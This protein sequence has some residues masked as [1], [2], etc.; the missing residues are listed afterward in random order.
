MHFSARLNIPVRRPRDPPEVD[1]G[2]TVE[3]LV[4]NGNKGV[5]QYRRKIIVGGHHATLQGERPNHLPMIV[6][7]LGHRTGPV[8]FEGVHLRQV[9]GVD[10]QETRRASHDRRS[11]YEQSQQQPT[12]NLP[13]GNFHRR[14]M[15]VKGF[16]EGLRPEYQERR[17]RQIAASKQENA[18]P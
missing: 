18:R 10:Q 2:M 16:H 15:L 5:A 7:N 6:V 3:I 13:P 17:Y 4:F 12:Y 9:R 11:Q 14:K 8:G 1:S